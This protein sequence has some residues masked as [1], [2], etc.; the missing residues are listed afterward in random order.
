M[1]YGNTKYPI[2]LFPDGLEQAI[3][4]RPRVILEKPVQP[5]K[6]EKPKEPK[7]QEKVTPEGFNV[8]GLFFATAILV[9][10]LV[11][12]APPGAIGFIIISYILLTL[13]NSISSSNYTEK[14]NNHRRDEF[15]KS[16]ETYQV[17]LMDYDREIKEYESEIRKHRIKI[18]EIWQEEKILSE[19]LWADQNMVLEHR[20]KEVRNYLLN[21]VRKASKLRKDDVSKKGVSE[22][23]FSHHLQSLFE[24]KIFV[25][26]KLRGRTSEKNYK[27][28]FVY[29]D[30]ATNLHIDI[31]IDEPYT[32]LTREAIHWKDYSDPFYNSPDD[33]LKMEYDSFGNDEITHTDRDEEILENGWPVVRFSE[34][35]VVRYPTKCCELIKEIIDVVELKR[36]FSRSFT[37]DLPIHDIWTYD[38]ADELSKANYRES[39]LALIK[40]FPPELSFPEYR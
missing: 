24:D 6:P 27:P 31:E 8:G 19:P 32:L 5:S 17:A 3:S 25:D 18:E 23:F 9:V 10:A 35:Q 20:R 33:F 12:K 11:M 13:F 1:E 2:I 22:R 40:Q 36:G 29:F 34:E 14:E 15:L 26:L 37:T 38:K 7:E 4:S 30:K 21:E 16:L 28:D 39:Y